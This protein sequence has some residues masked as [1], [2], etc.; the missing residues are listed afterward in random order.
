MSLRAI[1]QLFYPFSSGPVFHLEG[2][3][4]CISSDQGLREPLQ[5]IDQDHSAGSLRHRVCLQYTRENI[6]LGGMCG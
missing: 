2:I 1:C 6:Q 5:I 3:G 4:V